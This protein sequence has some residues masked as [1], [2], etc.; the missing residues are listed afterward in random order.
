MDDIS[1][2]KIDV[3][4]AGL[5][6]WWRANRRDLPWRHT[7]DPYR[8]MVSEIM[9]QQTQVDRVIPYYHRWFEVFPTVQDLAA[10]PTAEVI[11]LWAGLGYNRRAVNMQRTAQAV[12]E[13]GG[14]YPAT[15][16]ELLKLPGIGPYTAGAIACFAFEQDVPFIDTNMRRVLHRLFIGVDV[17]APVAS[18]KAITSLAAEVLPLGNGWNWNQGL[19]EFGALHCTARKPLCIVCPLQAECNAYPEIQ[20]AIVGNTKVA[21]GRKQVP[22]EQT[23]RYF[24]GRIVDALRVHQDDGIPLSDLGPLLRPEFGESDVPWLLEMVEGLER[25]GLAAIA[26]EEASYDVSE[27]RVRLP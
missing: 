22:F 27:T 20:T 1:P 9:L 13:R 2:A 17:P 26:E 18:D 10:A 3:V 4:R 16:Q 25:D 14:E 7:R 5:L 21:R 24:R 15:I 12:V 11:R 8:I 6:A 23:N 19:I